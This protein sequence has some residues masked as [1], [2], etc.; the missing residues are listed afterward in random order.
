MLTDVP[1]CQSNRSWEAIILFTIDV[2]WQFVDLTSQIESTYNN[3]SS[4]Y[5]LFVK[6]KFHILFNQIHFDILSIPNLLKM[7]NKA[8][9]SAPTQNQENLL[10]NF[11]VAKLPDDSLAY[12]DLVYLNPK[13]F[14]A[15]E[16]WKTD[17]GV[18]I[19][20]KDKVYGVQ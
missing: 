5:S 2:D 3:Y 18:F 16:K 4:W 20:V 7:A 10:R 12:T 13:D 9:Q 14:V 15:F 11:R 19:L 8:P 6:R 1:F 17:L